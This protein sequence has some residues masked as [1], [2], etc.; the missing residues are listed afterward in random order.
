MTDTKSKPLSLYDIA[1]QNPPPMSGGFSHRKT[2]ADVEAQRVAE[3]GDQGFGGDAVDAFQ[4]GAGQSAAG[5]AET[6]YQ[7]TGSETAGKLRDATQNWAE[8]Q[9]DQMSDSGREAMGKKFF[10]E[11]ENG[12]VQFGEAWSDPESIG[13]QFSN[14][15]G[16][17][18][19]QVVTGFGFTGAV[20]KVG[21]KVVT[22]NLIKRGLA[23]GMTK[24]AAQ[25][26]AKSMIRSGAGV[27]GQALAGAG[28]T[29]GQMGIQVR[30]EILN[31]SDTDLDE[32]NEFRKLYYQLHQQNPN[33]T[34]SE[35]RKTATKALAERVA[36]SVQADPL[37]ITAN[38]TLDA[39]GGRYIDNLIRGVGT[40]K[41]LTNAGMQAVGQGVPE[42]AQGGMEQFNINRAMVNEGV[43]PDRDLMEGVATNAL[44]EGVLGAGMGGAMGALTKGTPREKPSIQEQTSELT[45]GEPAQEENTQESHDQVQAMP[46]LPASVD[47]PYYMG[48]TEEAKAARQQTERAMTE[49]QGQ[50]P[51]NA[52][53]RMRPEDIEEIPVD[54]ITIDQEP[55]PPVADVEELPGPDAPIE[56]ESQSPEKSTLAIQDYEPERGIDFNSADRT[57]DL[58]DRVKDQIRKHKLPKGLDDGRLL[59][60]H[61]RS[62]LQNMSNELVPGGGVTYVRDKND[63]VVSRTPSQNPKWFQDAPDNVKRLGVKG[64]KKTIDQA[65]KGRALGKGQARAVRYALD[66]ITEDRND[67]ARTHAR[68]EREDLIKFRKVMRGEMT[69]QEAG[70]ADSDPVP[71]RYSD[72]IK[73]IAS[74]GDQRFTD[75]DYEAVPGGNGVG[76]A[77]ADDIREALEA[78]LPENVVTEIAKQFGDDPV[79]FSLRLF[80]FT[81]AHKNGQEV[82][83]A[84]VVRAADKRALEKESADRGEEPEWVK[85]ER[86]PEAEE[87]LLT[88]YTEEDLRQKEAERQQAEKVN[89][90]TE[91]KSQQKAKADAE[92]DSFALAGSDTE[93]DQAAARG[94]G[95]LLDENNSSSQ[96]EFIGKGV[97]DQAPGPG[98]QVSTA[99]GSVTTPF[100]E[101][102]VEGLVWE[103]LIENSVQE[104]DKRGDFWLSD[105]LENS[106]REPRERDV[107]MLAQYLFSDDYVSPEFK[108]SP[109]AEDNIRNGYRYDT[110]IDDTP[111]GSRLLTVSGRL[112]A[113][114]PA[115]GVSAGGTRRDHISSQLISSADRNAWAIDEAIAEAIARGDKFGYEFFSSFQDSPD[116]EAGIDAEAYLFSR[117]DEIEALQEELVYGEPPGLEDNSD[118]SAADK[119]F[120][121]SA[122]I[123]GKDGSPFHVNSRRGRRANV[124]PFKNGRPEIHSG[125]ETVD[126]DEYKFSDEWWSN[127]GIVSGLENSFGNNRQNENNKK[128][129]IRNSAGNPYKNKGAARKALKKHPGYELVEVE[130]GFELHPVPEGAAEAGNSDIADAPRAS[131]TEV[132][133]DFGPDAGLD[134][135]QAEPP[136]VIE[137]S[138]K[139]PKAEK[140][141]RPKVENK[142]FTEDAAEKARALL[143]KKLGQMNSGIDPE[144][145]QAGLTLA[146]YHIEKG[147]RTFAAFAKAM[148]D[149]LG[150]VVKPYLKS[151]YMGVKYDPRAAEFEGLDSAGEVESADIET[152]LE[153]GAEDALYP[154]GSSESDSSDRADA[155]TE[156]EE[157][158]S[159]ERSGEGRQPAAQNG[160]G[161]GRGQYEPDSPVDSRSS[162]PTG[163]RSSQP[164]SVKKSGLEPSPSRDTD[165]PRSDSA[166]TGRL[167]AEHQGP[168]ESDG[169]PAKTGKVERPKKLGAASGNVSPGSSSQIAERM[170]FLDSGQVEDVVFVENRL[171]KPDGYGVLLTNGTGTGKTFSGMG[172]VRRLLDQGK[173]N[174][175]IVTPSRAINDAWREAAKG[176]FDVAVEELPDT[177]SAGSGV[178]VT[179]FANFGGNDA[180]F[181]RNW[182]A[183]VIDEAHKLSQNEAGNDTASLRR[184]RGLAMQPGTEYTRAEALQPE[185]YKEIAE[186]RRTA[187]SI[188]AELLEKSRKA[189]EEQ[190]A[191][192]ESTS[193]ENRPRALMLSATPFAYEKNVRLGQGFLFDWGSDKDENVGY[194][195][196]GNYEQFMVEHFGYRMR[197][198]KLTEPDAKVDRN[199]LQRNFNSWLK[200]EG[201]LRGRVLETEF[202][203]DRKFIKTENA[204]GHRVDEA[205]KWLFE[206][207]EKGAHKLREVIVKGFD[208][209][210]RMYFLE[211]IKAQEVIPIVRKN[212]DLGRK[213]LIMHGFKKGGIT[214]P[215]RQST[216]DM[217][218]EIASV[219][220][221]FS[222]EFSDLISAFS[223]LPSAIDTLKNAFPDLMI[224]NGDV[225]NKERLAIADRFNDDSNTAPVL[226]QG[227][228]MREGVSLHDTTGKR[229]R[230]LLH[231]GM[232][233]EPT[234]TIQ[235]EGRIYRVGQASDAMFRYLTIDTSWE[236]FAFASRIAQRS[237][238]AENLAMGEVA[239][240]L[241]E[242][243]IEAYEQA[244]EFSISP[245]D[246]KGGKALDRSKAQQ[247]TEWDKAKAYYYGTKKQG[248]GRSS[249]GREGTDY[250]ATPEPVGL[251]MVEMANIRP[252]EDVLEPSGGHGAIARWFPDY[253]K[254]KAIEPS[255]D[256]ASK[257]SLRFSGDV[258]TGMFE[259]HHIV[260]KYDAIVM[261]P[262]YGHGGKT[263]ADHVGKA[264]A[265]LRDGGRIVALIP[266]GPAADK[267]FDKLLSSDAMKD[268]YTVADI[269][270]P[271][272]TFERAGTKV[273][274]RI[275][276][277]EKQ[278]DKDAAQSLRE[279]GYDYSSVKSVDEL[280]NRIEDL[281][282]PDRVVSENAPGEVASV[283]VDSDSDLDD[284]GITTMDSTHSKSGDPLFVVNMSGDMGDGYEALSK[285][286]KKHNGYYI[287]ARMRSYYKP[288]GGGKPEGTPTFTFSSEADRSEFLKDIQNEGVL[289]S[290]SDDVDEQ[291]RSLASQFSGN[292]RVQTRSTA[293]QVRGWLEDMA[294][295]MDS[296][297]VV[298]T[299]L[300]L[301]GRVKIDLGAYFDSADGAYDIKTGKTYIVAGNIRDQYHAKRVFLHEVVG[302]G[303]VINYLKQNEKLGGKAYLEMLDDIYYRAGHSVINKDI[304]RYAFDYDN[305]DERRIAVLEYI[306][307][308][309]EK[310]KKMGLVQRVIAALR[311]LIRR[312]NPDI[313]WTDTDTLALIEKG[314]RH[315]RDN[316]T[317]GQDG[318][319]LARLSDDLAEDSSLNDAEK[320]AL[321]KIGPK[322]PVETAAEKVRGVMDGWRLKVRQGLVDRYA[323]LMELDKK[324]LDGNITSEENITRSAWARAKMSNAASGAVS[325]MMNAGRIFMNKD[326]IVDVK[327]DTNGLIYTLNKLGSSAE[328]E[329]F[330]GWIAGNRGEKLMAEGR[331]NLFT[332]EDIQALKGLNRGELKNGGNRNALYEKVFKEFQQYR[333][334][335]LAI[336]EESGII[337]S[338]NREMWANEFYVPFYRL[339]EDNDDTT[340]PRVMGG[341]SRQ[342]AYKKLKGGTQNLND[343]LQNTL[344]N[345]HHLV[346]ASL[347][348]MAAKQGID[349][350]V[351]LG[352]AEKT[353][354]A[355]RDKKQSTF[356]LRNGEKEWYDIS[357]PMVYSSL[358][359]L[360]HTGMNGYAMSAMRWFKRTFTN[361]TTSTPQFVV[362]NLLRDS[363]SAVAVTDMKKN[364]AGNIAQGLKS[365]GLLDRNGYERARLMASGGA[366]SFGHVYGEDAD[367]IR[368]QIDGQ[369]RRANIVKNPRQ[370]LRLIGWDKWM[371]VN[372]SLENVNRAAAFK[373]AEDAG[374]GTMYAAFQAR[375]LMDF[376]A[377]GA[378]P[379]VRFLID[380]VPFL[381][382]RLQGLDKLY[383][384][385]VKPSTKVVLQMLGVGSIETSIEEKKAAARF[386]AVVGALSV[387]TMTLF[388][389]N[390]DDEE[391]RKAPDWLKDSYW[392]FRIPETDHVI[393]IPK[394]FEVGAIATVTE[395]L[396]EQGMDDE[397]TGKLFRERIWHMLTGTFS[398]SPVPQAF[399]PVLDVYANKD[400]FTE[401]QIETIGQS[402]LSKSNRVNEGTTGAAKM[403]SKVT[404]GVFGEDSNYALSPVQ[405]DFL[406]G[407]YLGQIGAWVSAIPDV[408]VRQ[409]SDTE[410]PSVF[411][412]EYQPIKRF[413]R[414][415]SRPSYTKDAELFYDS[416][417]KADR[418]YA[419]MR[420][421]REEGDMEEYADTLREN[422]DLLGMRKLL[423]QVNRRL[424][425]IRN[426]IKAI[427][428]N[429]SL[430]AEEKRR[431]IDLLKL[432]RNH[433]IERV[434]P[435]LKA[436]DA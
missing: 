139:K 388:A 307:H 288:N 159:D 389:H 207:K 392:W 335:V 400:S 32:S 244:D 122:V 92:V 331:E 21:A 294:E 238:T 301:P 269:K 341:L 163:K 59:R 248:S 261:N 7:I 362:A 299:S 96:E 52:P 35:L 434:S 338:E 355:A 40:G 62:I 6:V 246:G 219:Y 366:F 247:L 10:S 99:T 233:S 394:P 222:E 422:R 412:T 11:D 48:T 107:R 115:N 109:D 55:V 113:P 70:F 226:A 365:F 325:A 304:D 124:A 297:E 296:V 54:E 237:G 230:V 156:V 303:G 102:N 64:L 117:G 142:I 214:N 90:E 208:Y 160:K 4:M 97:H 186:L 185:V 359:S 168:R 20:A 47:A 23:K 287:R 131:A 144:I 254:N 84:S 405:M 286:A 199:L 41:R 217:P 417:R 1:Y 266:T 328:I 175:L 182:D 138:Q 8:G 143:K 267:Q 170:P 249:A 125:N 108:L 282:I 60:S 49:Q 162:A 251:K 329:R 234:A 67:Y 367:S 387:A 13:L 271:S 166:G 225:P 376:S 110:W 312:F 201:V 24:E 273:S 423:N 360:N 74:S 344:M 194:N 34:V 322:G 334:D 250:F 263:A 188:P 242:S 205:L 100:P 413:Y 343:L 87:E 291:I 427:E 342:Q 171:S 357:D 305:P 290:L 193:S 148:T 345:F 407:G 209:H 120:N 340:G 133:D 420:K 91:R 421:Y 19:G 425:E 298:E 180:L 369:M 424:Q 315:L 146:G 352:A 77:L 411:L 202:D 243:F 88:S 408:A 126:L 277:L 155:T 370:I 319:T 236:R 224:Y 206:N 398:F 42:A 292:S 268:I 195:S 150:N 232:P 330:M 95:N 61:F 300:D 127:G 45:E 69:P 123:R 309:A 137:E 349:N 257:L 178:V 28:I 239:R 29:G 18:A 363:M 371:D 2:A 324:L 262:P 86:E 118:I 9:I 220:D 215:F 30:D 25:E 31:L 75:A 132:N 306:A 380:V 260:N 39:I 82:R 320:S 316:G 154:A 270:M 403:L 368:Y 354:E 375:D 103:W 200:S 395:R 51:G 397:A 255:A 358:T 293:K 37:T 181:S 431:Q 280:F 432:R 382:A 418:L 429:G 390:Q 310:G 302:H 177:R 14:M 68:P 5:M 196:G 364:A 152:I 149:D 161:A 416:L 76:R 391:Y 63:R 323:G 190:R 339:D 130:G 80:V 98:E 141:A 399:Q 36:T 272:V 356:I 279:V 210:T 83:P 383:R 140:P 313:D 172:Y 295:G 281:E 106:P 253:T 414:D 385:G 94:Q 228:A 433:L 111:P 326:G 216:E 116:Q 153:Q 158:I 73:R 373:Q 428:K 57:D 275:L 317:S 415:A 278:T 377:H 147:A 274:T 204:L 283:S 435:K 198:N 252:G 44:N 179:T 384:S 284:L 81:E 229:Q 46:L 17:L 353:V 410:K 211:G 192:I 245:E 26:Y 173:S 256:L 289:A 351:E 134:A 221:E 72:A 346:D 78:G 187:Q 265:H 174:I 235:Q 379:A 71:Q 332:P 436:I 58:A 33:A 119:E 151:W 184:L 203:Y 350:T 66:H 406:I 393:T 241:K 386:S 426:R 101:R 56:F 129:I 136:E 401:R 347:K 404:T 43:D 321:S 167:L 285:A 93:A 333:D 396:L 104:A 85:G 79:E 197:Y 53:A 409:F 15:A 402:R 372:N 264:G 38:L 169:R 105:R 308:L 3:S 381:N 183:I 240:G 135:D 348:N 374:K 164:V 276:V 419:D 258:M 337:T 12:D 128:P 16:Q 218:N 112:T 189:V 50:D 314:R 259:D 165:H 191:L 27:T 223:R 378:W 22:K 157:N 361:L 318:G 212:L 430:S 311:D 327:K 213:V 65:L 176:F 121:F 231:L 336:A 227:A 145:L 89:S 114:T